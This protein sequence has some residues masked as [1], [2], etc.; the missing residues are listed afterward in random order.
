MDVGDKTEGKTMKVYL[1]LRFQS[2]GNVAMTVPI[3]SAA[4]K[5]QPD[6]VF[7]VVAK[8]R[9]HA[10]FY[11]M[12]NVRFHEVD[13]GDGSIKGLLQVYREL[14]QYHIDH[15]IDLQN[16]LRTFILRLLFRLDGI[17]S[18][19]IKYGRI[20]KWVIA[21]LGIGTSQPLPTEFAR[22]A[23]TL[24]RAGIETDDRFTALPVN[25][26]AA[27][28]VAQRFGSKE[29]KWI[30]LAPFAKSK[31]NMLPYSTIK[32]LLAQ[33]DSEGDKR[34]FL[35]GAGKV[36]CELLR[37]WAN[38]YEHV[39]SVAGELPL[40][41]E[42]ELMRR[43][44]VIICMDSANQHLASLVGLRAV[45]IWCGTH[46]KMGF[47]GWKQRDKDRIEIKNLACR[48][49]SVHG[50]NHCRYRNFACQQINVNQ[51]KEVYE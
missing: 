15:V 39:Q 25:Q 1:V 21:K 32:G 50:S 9:L 35:F 7:V 49:C 29:G 47:Y 51:I 43:L 22:Y 28:K 26:A 2:L 17:K 5:L 16:V 14:K 3:L 31:T 41:E 19:T 10:M 34:I 37:Q 24:R 44:D 48:P 45:S 30:G 23:E 18:T 6:D 4:S 36:E 12:E 27:D 42:L 11:G 33:M 38:N 46:P 40:E 8:K 13:F 20:R